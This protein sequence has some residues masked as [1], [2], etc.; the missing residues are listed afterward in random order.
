MGSRSIS[1]ALART[2]R[3]A[4]L[5]AIVTSLAGAAGCSSTPSDDA[6]AVAQMGEAIDASPWPFDGH[7]EGDH[8]RV[9]GLSK[10]DGQEE[11]LR[12]LEAAL[13]ELDGTPV[14]TSIFFPT[15][16]GALA[17]GAMAGTAHV[18]D[19]S[20]A[21][22]DAPAEFKLFHRKSTAEVVALS[23]IGHSFREGHRYGCW[24]D[25]KVVRPSSEMSD[26]LH[27]RGAR[28]AIYAPLVTKLGAD[29][30][31]VG[32]ATVFTVGHPTR[33][34]DAMRDV[35]DGTALPR[36][37][38]DKVI[39]GDAALDD[40]FGKPAT[41]RSGLG[42][43]TGITHDQV[44]AVVLGTFESPYFLDNALHD[45]EH[46]GRIALDAAGKPIVQGVSTVPFMLTLPRAPA[47][48][49]LG[50][51]PVMIFQHGLNAGRWQVTTVANDY[52][53]AGYASIGIDALWHG[54][55]RPGH[56]DDVHNF[57][58]AAGADGIADNDDLGASLIFFDFNGDA[59]VSTNALDGRC[60][61]D[62]FRQAVLDVTELTR[63]LKEG[64]LSAVA[65]ADPALASL[66]LDASHLVYT[67]ESFGSILGAMSLAT[68]ARLDAGVLS[69]GGAGI[70]LPTFANSPFFARIAFLF[71]KSGFDHDL[72]V[73]DPVNLPAEAQRSLSLLQA[74][75]EPG[76]PV[77]FAPKIAR[78]PDVARGRKSK[79]LLLLQANGDELIPNQSGE[80]LASI[81]GATAVTIE[82]HTK[83]LRY[84]T[85]PVAAAPFGGSGAPTIAILNVDP[86][87]HTMFTGYKAQR[88]YE[89]D[90][91]P[92]KKLPTPVDVDNP[93]EW[94][95]GL[96]VGVA[97]GVRSDPPSV[98]VGP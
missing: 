57:S 60:V 39:T 92:P 24:I 74:A 37:R 51:T 77:A 14:K 70:F 45:R 95:H 3:G 7:R 33:V 43:P 44:F 59:A 96:A 98:V 82:G 64:D 71:L 13:S 20:D 80:L 94:L 53:R 78:F 79:P 88:E 27:G 28:A 93:I 11:K 18:I 5:C 12:D 89:P 87:T 38:V 25:D 9:T 46:L 8:L 49:D 16:G 23:P 6:R 47:G 15:S 26:A 85:L 72:D 50:K 91:P 10:F 54:E 22:A 73:S 83:P 63:L 68:D 62:N 84:V 4:A 61:R 21:E 1:T 69:V 29:A 81:S 41:T 31:H 90:F 76:D 32:A 75:L 55:R 2:A 36:A 66:T 67:S 86:A 65:A 48:G 52:A 19:L 34:L 17:D 40:F 58:G 42:D 56:K 35:A 30:A 97:K